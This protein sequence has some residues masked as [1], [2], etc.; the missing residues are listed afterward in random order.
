MNPW[1]LGRPAS[2]RAAV[3][4]IVAFTFITSDAFANHG[5]GTSGGGSAT[6]SGETL[7]PG[8]FDLSLR[9]DYTKFEHISRAGAERQ[10]LRS[11]EFDALSDATLTS[12]GISYGV[13]TDFQ[14]GAQIGY[15]WGNNF[16]DAHVEEDGSAGSDTADP[17]GITDL[18]LTAKY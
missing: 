15:Y 4:L 16:I 17:E 9:V 7:K 14:I 13:F 8:Q 18:S 3:L 5:P 12:L 10:A 1:R 2:L 6:A 11:D